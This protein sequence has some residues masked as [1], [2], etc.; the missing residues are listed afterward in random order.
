[1]KEGLIGMSIVANIVVILTALEF[2]FIFYLE[3]IA[4][5]SKRTASVFNME[6]DELKKESVSLLFKNQGVYNLIIAVM[7]PASLFLVHSKAAVV[8]FLVNIIAVAAYGGISLNPRIF[9]KQGTL[10]VI[11]LILV[12]VAGI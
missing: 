1:M 11:A 8:L 9:F 12:L 7:L 6:Q 4:T 3:T 10:A 5:T 2:V